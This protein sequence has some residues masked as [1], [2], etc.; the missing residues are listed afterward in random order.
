MNS[1]VVAPVALKRGR[2]TSKRSPSPLNHVPSKPDGS[3]G[4]LCLFSEGGRRRSAGGFTEGSARFLERSE[5]FF[6]LLEVDRRFSSLLEDDRLHFLEADLFR[7]ERFFFEDAGLLEAERFLFDE[8]FLDAERFL[9]D[10]RFLEDVR[11]FGESRLFEKDRFLDVS[12]LLEVERF[13]NTSRLFEEE[14]FLDLPR[15][16]E[17]ERFRDASGLFEVER[18]FDVSRLLD[19]ELTLEIGRCPNF[20]PRLSE[21]E[22][23]RRSSLSRSFSKRSRSRF[24][25][26]LRDFRRRS[27]PRDQVRLLRRRLS[28]PLHSSH[29]SMPAAFAALQSTCSTS[30]KS[31]ID[32]RTNLRV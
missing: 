22:R 20:S 14:C 25:L 31:D 4:D 11:L 21:V 3:E 30:A 12:R 5:R 23:L 17:A 27:R 26:W 24:L 7:E 29:L 15:P 6:S 9:D 16:F 18:V 8:C 2:G 32:T 28:R 10:A 19:L 1:H 13:L